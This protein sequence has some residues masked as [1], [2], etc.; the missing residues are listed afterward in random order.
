MPW[1]WTYLLPSGGVT[2]ILIAGLRLYFRD[3]AIHAAIRTGRK[4]D[5]RGRSV[6]IGDYAEG[7]QLT[8]AGAGSSG[9]EPASGDLT[10]IAPAAQRS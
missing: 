4:L 10:D 3:R 7:T 8:P 6:T 5:I 1:V 9:H 2:T